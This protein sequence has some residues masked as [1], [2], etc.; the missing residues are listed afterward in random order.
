MAAFTDY[1]EQNLRDHFKNGTQL[2][3]EDPYVALLTADPGETGSTAGEPGGGWYSRQ[4]VHTTGAASTPRWTSAT[5]G[6][7]FENASAVS[8]PTATTTPGSVSYFA[9]LNGTGTTATMLFKASLSSATNIASG[10]Q[11]TFNAGDV[12]ITF[13]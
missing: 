3:L 5:A 8:F 1:L 12:E 4:Q 6:T 7:G 13:D 9:I 11:P 10:N 2:P